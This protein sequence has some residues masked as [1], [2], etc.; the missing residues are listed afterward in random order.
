MTLVQWQ[1]CA[2]QRQGLFRASLLMLPCWPRPPFKRA[3][4]SLN[5]ALFAPCSCCWVAQR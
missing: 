2:M 1:V 5:S 4:A 3:L